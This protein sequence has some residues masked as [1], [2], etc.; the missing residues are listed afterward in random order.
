MRVVSTRGVQVGSHWGVQTLCVSTRITLADKLLFLIF[1]FEV[2]YEEAVILCVK[3]CCQSFVEIIK[4][5]RQWEIGL[6]VD[7]PILVRFINNAQLVLK[8]DRLYLMFKPLNL[9]VSLLYHILA[10]HEFIFPRSCCLLFQV[11]AAWDILHKAM[12]SHYGWGA[13]QFLKNRY[14]NLSHRSKI[15]ITGL[16]SLE[17]AEHLI[18][19]CLEWR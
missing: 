10:L 15:M 11:F 19:F 18:G 8:R 9:L 14:F 3:P 2:A 1:S 17:G 6:L 13:W 7:C 12:P 5:I 16:F 4:L